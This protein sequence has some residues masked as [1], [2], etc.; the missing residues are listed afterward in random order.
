MPDQALGEEGMEVRFL[1]SGSSE[2]HEFLRAS[3][4]AFDPVL[5]DS[6]ILGRAQFSVSPSNGINDWKITVPARN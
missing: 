4:E 6:S 5:V 3:S 2:L 1:M